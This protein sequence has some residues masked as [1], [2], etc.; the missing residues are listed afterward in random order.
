ML[1]Q[2]GNLE[3]CKKCAEDVCFQAHKFSS[4]N[5]NFLVGKAKSVVSGAYKQQGN[6][7]KAAECLELS[8]E[9]CPYVSLLSRNKNV[10]N[11]TADIRAKREKSH[12]LQTNEQDEIYI[13]T[14]T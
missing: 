3:E 1:Y 4:P 12:L 8:T 11:D 13:T 2:R 14:T 10:Q 5:Y 6:F 7:E 9:V